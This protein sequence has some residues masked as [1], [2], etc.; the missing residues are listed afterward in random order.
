MKTLE[1]HGVIKNVINICNFNK[2]QPTS[3]L[4]D[5][6]I[7]NDPNKIANYF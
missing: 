1:K 6:E 2:G 7:S 3:I 5:G 4:I